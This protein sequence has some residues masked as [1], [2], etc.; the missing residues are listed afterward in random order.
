MG[1][2]RRWLIR[3]PVAAFRD[4]SGKR[5]LVTGSSPN[6]IGFAVAKILLQWGASVT[7][8]RRREAQALVPL[9]ESSLAKPCTGRVFAHDLDLANAKSVTQF[10]RWYQRS[11]GALDVLINCAGIHLDLL[12]QW[13]QPHLSDDGHE[14]HWRTNYLGTVQLSHLLLPLLLDSASKTG[15]ARLVN[16]I[17]MLHKRGRNADFFEQRRPYN[18]W[19][20]YGQSKLGLAH[21]TLELQRRYSDRGLQACCLHPGEVFSNIA[22]KGLA[23]NPWLER[24]RRALAPVEAFFLMTPEEGAQTPIFC[25]TATDAVGG[26]YYKNCQVALPSAE[27]EDKEVA[28]R[29]WQAGLGWMSSAHKTS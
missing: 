4:M 6:S 29:L 15:D 25:A 18:S 5:V 19:N 20:A 12:S 23:G 13:Q 8:T 21:F 26:H 14:I 16:V 22:G 11:V 27:L 28:A 24:L 1:V 7:V 2:A 9:L 3:K 10:A 17:S